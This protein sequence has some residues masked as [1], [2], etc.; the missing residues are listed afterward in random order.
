MA[1]RFT[2]T[3]KWKKK[4]IRQLDPK[5]K[6]FWFYLLCAILFL[7]LGVNKSCSIY[8]DIISFQFIA[9][10]PPSAFSHLTRHQDDSVLEL[11]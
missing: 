9:S 4:W 11:P 10:S 3:G 6:L 8:T 5:Y 1:K 2:E 7:K